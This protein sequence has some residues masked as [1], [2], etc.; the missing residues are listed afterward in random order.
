M[1]LDKY[2][3]EDYGQHLSTLT[4]PPEILRK[5]IEQVF[6]TN[7]C[8]TLSYTILYNIIYYCIC[9]LSSSA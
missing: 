8:P 4:T 5:N 7:T 2:D 1:L 6:K 9:W 3:K